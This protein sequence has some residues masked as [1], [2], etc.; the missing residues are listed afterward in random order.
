MRKD[1]QPLLTLCFIIALVLCSA[2]AAQSE[3]TVLTETLPGGFMLSGPVAFYNPGNLF[4]LINGQA[5]FYLSYGFSKLDHAFYEKSGET[6]KVDIYELENHLSAMGSYREQKDD[7]TDELA[8][9]CEGYII[10][11][12]SA[13]YKDRYYVEIVPETDG[14]LSDLEALAGAVADCLPGTNELP[15]ELGLFPREGLVPGSESYYGES[16]LSYTFL[17]NGMSAH[18]RQGQD[19]NTLRIFVSFADDETEAQTIAGTFAD[20]LKNKRPVELAGGLSGSA[21]ELAYR[22]KALVFTRGRFAFGGIGVADE[23][24]AR[25]VLEKLRVNLQKEAEK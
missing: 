6:Y 16:L 11:Y 5:V 19:E 7:D 13:F 23:N 25:T 15:P 14:V 10:D 17:G 4:E 3:T 1:I 2:P 20:N 9:G 8:V 24:T 22:G 12:L 21:G 18:Y